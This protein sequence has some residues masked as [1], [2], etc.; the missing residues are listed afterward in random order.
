M[1]KPKSI[2]AD[3]L[4]LT[5]LDMFKNMFRFKRAQGKFSSRWIPG[6][7]PILLE[8]DLGFGAGGI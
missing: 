1:K 2:G 7:F 6:I 5:T 4:I 8:L 3:V